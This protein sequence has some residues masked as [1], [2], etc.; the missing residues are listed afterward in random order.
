MKDQ[1]FQ[2]FVSGTRLRPPGDFLL[3]D[4]Q[5]QCL[6][7]RRHLLQKTRLFVEVYTDQNIVR[8]CAVY[9]SSMKSF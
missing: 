3:K 5:F 7:L 2:R 4:Q 6:L 8:H 1:Q 9:L